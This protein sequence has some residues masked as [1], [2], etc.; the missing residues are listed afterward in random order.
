MMKCCSCNTVSHNVQIMSILFFPLE[1]VRKIINSPDDLVTLD[2]CFEFYEAPK[3]LKIFCNYCK[4]YSTAYNQSKIIIAPKTLII[5]LN[6]GK[7]Y[8]Y[9]V[10]IQFKELLNLEDNIFNS[11]SSPFYYELV[12]VISNLDSNDFG[13]H[14]IEFCKNSYDCKWYK[15]NDT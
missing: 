9:N 15:Y 11:Q 8:Q 5:N 12:G 3:L 14:F 10:G 2:N 1:R 6:R 4:K 13:G 7:G